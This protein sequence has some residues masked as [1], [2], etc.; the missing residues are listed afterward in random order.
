MKRD[1]APRPPAIP[2]RVACRNTTP[3][4]LIA[5][6]R[7]SSTPRLLAPP[8]HHVHL[9]LQL[10]GGAI[11]GPLALEPVARLPL[12]AWRRAAAAPHVDH[13]RRLVDR[14]ELGLFSLRVVPSGG[15]RKA[16]YRGYTEGGELRDEGSGM[17]EASGSGGG[18]SRKMVL[19]GA[20]NKFQLY[21]HWYHVLKP[22]TAP[23]A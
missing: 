22:T 10:V 3:P 1:L 21:R 16:V 20:Q 4:H 18:K 11:A 12:A 23:H 5:V 13:G 14:A 19:I 2:I 7:P 9:P 15:T 6:E 8:R 17:D